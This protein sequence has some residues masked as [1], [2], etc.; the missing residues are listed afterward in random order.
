MRCG[1]CDLPMI[2]HRQWYRQNHRPEGH[3]PCGNEELELCRKH[4]RRYL[5]NG[6]T[7]PVVRL[8]RPRKSR[9]VEVRVNRT[10]EEV[11]EDYAMI[12]DH[13]GS[14][15]QAAERMGMTFSALDMALYRARKRGDRRALPP[16]QQLERGHYRQAC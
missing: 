11:L 5:R 9:A 7:E 16:L 6:S 3:V 14:V 10:S 2:P 15:A 13:V 12:R 4:Y 1:P 8:R